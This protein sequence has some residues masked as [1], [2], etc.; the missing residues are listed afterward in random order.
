MIETELYNSDFRRLKAEVILDMLYPNMKDII[1]RDKGSFYRGYNPDLMDID[2]SRNEIELSR[3]GTLKF[4][5]NNFLSNDDELNKDI[6]ERSEIVNRRIKLLGDAFMPIDTYVF[7]QCLKAQREVDS[8]LRDKAQNILRI[9]F[10][11]DVTQETNPYIAQ[12]AYLLPFA[13]LLKGK[14][15][16]LKRLLTIVVEEPI[17]SHSYPYS[18][19]DTTVGYMPKTLFSVQKSGLTEETYPEYFSQIKALRDFVADWFIPFDHIF[20]MEVVDTKA[21]KNELLNYNTKIS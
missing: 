18:A 21:G 11:Y 15:G 8:L 13:R 12:I 17:V 9:F 3:D 16:M 1:V 20:E 4:L 2:L 5:P 14:I 6:R 7:M 10:N 19:L